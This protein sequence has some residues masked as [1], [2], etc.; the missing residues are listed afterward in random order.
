MLVGGASALGAASVIERGCNFA[1]N[2]LAARFAG[3][4]M[5]GAYSLALTTANNVATYA[6]AG[7]GTTANRFAGMY[8]QGSA[9]YPKLVRSLTLVSVASS[10]LAIL[11]LFAGAGPLARILLRS[12]GLTPL[13]QAAAISAGMMILLECLRGFLIGERQYRQLAVLALC[14]GVSLV[15]A[16]PMAARLG[17]TPMIVSQAAVSAIAITVCLAVARRTHERAPVVAVNEPAV[18]PSA[19]AIWRFGM[20]QFAGVLGLNAA[21]WWV[22]ALV[23]RADTTLLQA[24]L[25]AVANQLRNLTSLAPNLFTQ[26]SYSLLADNGEGALDRRSAVLVHCTYFAAILS[27]AIGGTLAAL[28]VWVLPLVFGSS[29]SGA[30][31][32][33]SLAV[34]TAVVHMTSSPAAARLTIVSLPQTGMINA[35]WT[36][37]TIV[38]ASFLVPRWGAAA[39]MGVYFG[40]HCVSACLV[41]FALRRSDV[42][43]AGLAGIQFSILALSMVLAGLAIARAQVA[44]PTVLFSL[45]MLGVTVAGTMALAIHGRQQGW[46]PRSVG[47]G[48]LRSLLGGARVRRAV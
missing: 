33:V 44:A 12:P 6:G 11:L 1:A 15:I 45:L 25:F 8:R 39:A 13:L 32:A 34:A 46:L 16:L 18:P 41:F 9:G 19:G 42:I 40:V 20:V 4:Q 35:A 43:P 29:F 3:P 30:S 26:S 38:A 24:G 10:G 36:G 48:Q 22:A 23:A 47:V 14:G 21:G 5:F 7:I 2:L 31:L 17:A 27:L 37:I 28:A